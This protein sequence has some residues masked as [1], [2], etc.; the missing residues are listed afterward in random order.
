VFERMRRQ[1]MVEA[2]WSLKTKAHSGNS[3]HR[4]RRKL[5]LVKHFLWLSFLCLLQ[6]ASMKKTYEILWEKKSYI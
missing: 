2:P 4:T 5:L 1:R 6:E 3:E